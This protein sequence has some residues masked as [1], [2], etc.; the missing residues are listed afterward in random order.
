MLIIQDKTNWKF[1]LIVA[2]LAA[3]VGGGILWFSQQQILFYQPLEIKIP[4]KV[5]DETANWKIDEI[6]I[7]TFAN[8]EPDTVIN[9]IMQSFNNSSSSIKFSDPVESS[10]WW[11]SDDGWSIFDSNAISITATGNFTEKYSSFINTLA[12]EIN[13]EISKIFLNNGFTLNATNTSKSVTDND[14]YDYV[15]A[16]Q[17]GETRC[18][19]TTNGDGGEYYIDCSNRFQEAYKEQI[20]YLKALGIR[21]VIVRVENRIG[22]YVLLGVHLR[23]TGY[24]ALM[25]DKGGKIKF[26]FSGQE[27]PQCDL[28]IK[29]QVPKEVYKELFGGCYDASGS[30]VE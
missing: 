29:N 30:P 28:M 26:I 22:D 16:F 18:I 23:R 12:R 11:I 21:D 6:N 25:E 1:L 10:Q 27:P 13:A 5:N 14:F 8:D 19:L 2:I 3:I 17:K 9:S 20:P 15:V 7:P 24:L 4:E